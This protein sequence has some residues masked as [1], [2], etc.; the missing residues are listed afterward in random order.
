MGAAA[1]A[2]AR[3]LV[4]CPQREAKD[5]PVKARRAVAAK[6]SEARKLVG[7]PS[8]NVPVL[9]KVEHLARVAGVDLQGTP[10]SLEQRRAILRPATHLREVLGLGVEHD[11]ARSRDEAGEVCEV[12][13]RIES[14]ATRRGV[15]GSGG[16]VTRL[17]KQARLH[18][19][20]EATRL[21]SLAR[22]A[23]QAVSDA[24]D[25]RDYTGGAHAMLA[26]LHHA[27]SAA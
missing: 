1:D 12:K 5:R 23:L 17:A 25:S 26:A 10:W 6:H 22:V 20:P 24:L 19:S 27:A 7:V 14:K 18:A 2:A 11:D 3:R 9:D 8:K 4:V 21:C 13:R 15:G 16:V